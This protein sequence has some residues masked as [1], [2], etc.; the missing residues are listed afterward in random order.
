VEDV[1]AAGALLPDEDQ[2]R[3][4]LP[5]RRDE[6][7]HGVVGEES[8]DADDQRAMQRQSEFLPGGHAVGGPEALGIDAVG[9]ISIRFAG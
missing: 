4:G 1:A 2:L 7:V 3:P 5:G 6:K 9:T 8:T